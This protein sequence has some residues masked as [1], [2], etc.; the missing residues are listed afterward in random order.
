L[1]CRRDTSSQSNTRQSGDVSTS[2]DFRS[3]HR[4]G[5]A[6]PERVARNG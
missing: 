1:A 2:T 5:E 6:A 3:P 4:F